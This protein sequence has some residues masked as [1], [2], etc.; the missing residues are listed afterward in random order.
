MDQND[1]ND[2]AAARQMNDKSLQQVLDEKFEIWLVWSDKRLNVAP[3]QTALEVLEAAGVPV[4]PG[5]KSGGCG[6]CATPYVEGALIHKDACLNA[7]E[8]NKM[9]CPCVS[10]AKGTLVLPF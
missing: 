6:E 8:R 5:C 4:E 10:R 2:E 9:F 1:E 3:V 7:G